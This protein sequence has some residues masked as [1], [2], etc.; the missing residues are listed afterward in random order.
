[1]K[2]EDIVRPQAEDDDIT[3][4]L[5]QAYKKLK[6]LEER[7]EK[8]K[9]FQTELKELRKFKEFIR[10]HAEPYI[11]EFN[12]AQQKDREELAKY[13]CGNKNAGCGCNSSCPNRD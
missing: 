11:V 8:V 5:V 13:V 3:Q 6:E 7:F 9:K 10:E 12:E 1:M 4:L 2:T